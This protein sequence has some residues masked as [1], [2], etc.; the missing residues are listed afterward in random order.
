MTMEDCETLFVE[1][2]EAGFGLCGRGKVLRKI[3]GSTIHYR[4]QTLVA[5]WK[6]WP[7]LKAMNARKVLPRQVE[8]WSEKFAN[9]YSATR[10]NNTRDSCGHSFRSRSTPAPGLT[11][12]PRK[13]AG[14]P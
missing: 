8:T 5:L 1:R 13:S 4:K 9:V 12:H 14:W 6:S 10:Y 7:E 3:R 2:L 11:T